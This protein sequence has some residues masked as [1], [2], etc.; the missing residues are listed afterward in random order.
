MSILGWFFKKNEESHTNIPQG[1]NDI[2]DGNYNLTAQDIDPEGAE[3]FNYF[4]RAMVLKKEGRISE[5][6]ALLIKSTE[7]PSIYKGHYRELFKVW[8]KLNRDDLK[9]KKYQEVSN[10]VLNMHRL[11]DEMINEMLRYWSIQQKRKLPKDYFDNDRNLLVSDAKILRKSAEFL[12]NQE[13][14]FLSDKLL[15]RF[16]KKLL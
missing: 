8:R 7:R 6:E 15:E 14:V 10:R 11:D 9:A 3:L 2:L 12:Q 13:C 5:A 16:D 4:Q 1:A